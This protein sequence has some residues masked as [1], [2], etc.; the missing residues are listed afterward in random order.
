MNQKTKKIISIVLLFAILPFLLFAIQKIT[1]F[2]KKATPIPAN[3]LIDTTNL[4]GSLNSAMWQNFSQGGEEPKDMIGP[5]INQIKALSPKLI[6]VDHLF[7][8]YDVYQSPGQYNF[9]KLDQIVESIISTGATP[10]L[11][12]SYTPPSMAKNNQN[13][14]EPNNW[15]DWYQLIKATA[16]RYSVDK[17]IPNI[18]YEVWNEPD[19]FGS[20]HYT[21][22]PSYTTLFIQTNKAVANGINNQATYKIGGPAITAFYENW[23]KSLFKTATDNN[24]KLDFISWHK[25]SKNISDFTADSDKLTKIL[26]GYPDFFG[27]ERIISEVGPNSEPDAWYDNYMSGIH[28]LALTTQLS[29]KIHKIF[30]FE[31]VDG[32]SPR[33]AISSGW[34]LLTHPNKGAQPKPRFLAIQFLNQLHGQKVYAVGDG[35]FITSISTKDKNII[36][37]LVVNYDPENKHYETFP[38]TYQ[39]IEPGKYQLKYTHF[40]GDS[41]QKNITVTGSSY[42]EQVYMEPNTAVLIELAQSL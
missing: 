31:V 13:A 39:N 23:I 7:D 18:Y 3:I 20:W 4:Q 26:S 27:I 32:P 29:G 30:T 8:Y 25:Y 9:S 35:S 1:E 41:S 14:G 6:R 37:T 5:V 34:G 19:L 28:L 42:G 16:R 21:K 12:L 24:L 10:I 2:R 22:N 36:Q 33:S 11:S 15:D 40:L 17:K 38:I